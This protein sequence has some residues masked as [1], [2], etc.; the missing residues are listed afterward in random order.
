MRKASRPRKT[1]DYDEFLFLY[2][3]SY[4]FFFSFF[5]FSVKFSLS[6]HISF[7]VFLFF[8]FLD[9]FLFSS[10]IKVT[11]LTSLLFSKR[12]NQ[13]VF[14]R[15]LK[16]LAFLSLVDWMHQS[17]SGL[18]VDHTGVMPDL[19]IT[20]LSACFVVIQSF[21]VLCCPLFKAFINRLWF[22]NS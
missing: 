13:S 14:K 16:L 9:S 20:V 6:K 3:D 18:C 12:R 21:I 15:H 5:F 22:Q 8:F 11:F 4:R 10:G 2:S 17:S 7:P 1:V 19:F